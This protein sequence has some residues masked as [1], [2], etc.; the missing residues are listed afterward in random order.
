M[1]RS[2][3]FTSALTLLAACLALGTTLAAAQTMPTQ[4]GKPVSLVVSF[5]AGGA[6]DQIARLLGQQLQARWKVPV[7]VNNKPGAAGHLGNDSVARAEP[8]GHT[9]LITP[10]TFTMAPHVLASGAQKPAD[11]LTD[12]TPIALLSSSSMLLLAHPSLGVK[13]A[14]EL[15]SKAKADK[16]LSYAS[17]G[18][19]TPMH[20]AG[21]LFNHVAGLQLDH[22]PYRGTTPAINDV[23]GGHVKLTY[24]GLPVAKPL[25]D[26]GKLVPLAVVDKARSPLLPDVPTMAEQGFAGVETDIWFGVYGP[27]GLPKALADDIHRAVNDALKAPEVA[28][29]FKTMSQVVHNESREAFANKT[30]A[31]HQRYGDIIR[32]FRITAD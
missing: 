12:F 1:P 32:Q 26:A 14:R 15:A 25:I 21:E 30:R 20:I 19:G 4:A 18:N 2:L 9:L 13:N 24:L 17:S 31:D 28:A 11:V 8:D 23:L 5:P 6:P 3:A 22:V 27:K 10:N 29:Q 16:G 7:V